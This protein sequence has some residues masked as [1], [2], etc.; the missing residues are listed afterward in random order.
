[1]LFALIFLKNVINFFCLRKVEK[2]II[3]LDGME[4]K[5]FLYPDSELL[6]A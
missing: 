1:M 2:Y 3:L 6:I 5:A 4:L